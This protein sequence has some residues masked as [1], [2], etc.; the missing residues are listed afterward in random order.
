MV[1]TLETHNA[2]I[3]SSCQTLGRHCGNG[4]QCWGPECHR[5]QWGVCHKYRS[6][7]QIVWVSSKQRNGQA[8]ALPLQ[9]CVRP[10]H[11][12]ADHRHRDWLLWGPGDGTEPVMDPSGS[13]WGVICG[14]GQRGK[15][16]HQAGGEGGPGGGHLQDLLKM[17]PT[18]EMC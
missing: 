1:Q 5:V 3:K 6:P 10:H 8:K 2:W 16:I 14:T 4:D 17:R 12:L 15:D 18:I 9:S 13:L 11:S 7:Y